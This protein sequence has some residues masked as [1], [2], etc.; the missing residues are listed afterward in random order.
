MEQNGMQEEKHDAGS[1]AHVARRITLLT[2]AAYTSAA[3]IRVCDTILPQLA[4]T[5]GISTGQASHVITAF[6]VAYGLF[7]LF[8]GPL[9]DRYNKYRLITIAAFACTLGN[10]GAAASPSLGWLIFFRALTGSTAAA[11]I[12]LSMAW[13]GDSVPYERRQATLARFLSGPLLGLISGQFLGGFFSDTLGWQWCFIVLAVIYVMVGTFLYLELRRDKPVHPQPAALTMKPKTMSFL[14]QVLAVLHVRW[15]L[16]VLITVFFEGTIGFGALAF[17]PSH[18][19]ASFGISLTLAGSLTAAFGLGGL[20]YTIIAARLVAQIGERGLAFGAAPLLGVAFLMYL[21]G[22]DWPWALPA[23][24]TLGLGF[25]MLHNTLQTNATQMAPQSRGTAV[26]LFVATF[27]LG[28]S[29]GVSLAAL[30]V[31]RAGA[32]WL[33]GL[34]AL[35]LPIVSSCFAYA[36]RFRRT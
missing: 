23:S 7:Q 13:I 19:H 11:I 14:D 18:L 28:Q 22:P 10:I 1:K 9:G 15:A 16:V 27:F 8:Y 17:V 21:L 34:A 6:A 35:L 32:L 36:L 30:V 33:F 4:K 3:S 29:A 25:Y 12:P 5:F 24:F 31:D 2:F 20:L 26:A